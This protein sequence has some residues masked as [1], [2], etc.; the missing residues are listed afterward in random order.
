MYSAIFHNED[1]Y[2]VAFPDWDGVFRQGDDFQAACKNAQE[3]MEL[4]IT[5]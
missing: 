4:A 1:G 5:S 3:A 2:W